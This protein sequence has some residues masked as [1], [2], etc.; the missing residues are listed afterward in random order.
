V[1]SPGLLEEL[2]D[3]LW[4]ETESD[5]SDWVGEAS[6]DDSELFSGVWSLN[7][8]KIRLIHTVK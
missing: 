3:E 7:G 5:G 4:G 8:K 6:T 2:E 1:S